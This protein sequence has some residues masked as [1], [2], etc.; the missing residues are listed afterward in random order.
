M[1]THNTLINAMSVPITILLLY[2]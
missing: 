2:Q 1:I